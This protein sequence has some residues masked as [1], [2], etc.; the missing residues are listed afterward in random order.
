MCVCG[1]QTT[2]VV[3]I[4]DGSSDIFFVSILNPSTGHITQTQN[5]LFFKTNQKSTKNSFSL[6]RPCDFIQI[7]FN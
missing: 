1:S 3:N 7:V 4:I 6:D 5:L 2:S